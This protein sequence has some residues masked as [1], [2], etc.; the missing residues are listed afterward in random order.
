MRFEGQ[1]FLKP[2]PVWTDQGGSGG[3]GGAS[4]SGAAVVTDENGNAITDENGNAITTE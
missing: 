3:S 4:G 1:I 2:T